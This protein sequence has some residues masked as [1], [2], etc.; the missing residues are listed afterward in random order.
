M[1]DALLS[2][3]REVRAS[4]SNGQ[5]LD[6]RI[7]LPGIAHHFGAAITHPFRAVGGQRTHSL[8]AASS[9]PGGWATACEA[10]KR[11][12]HDAASDSRRAP[13]L[14]EHWVFA[15]DSPKHI[16]THYARRMGLSPSLAGLCA[17]ASPQRRP[18]RWP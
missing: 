4:A 10:A 1:C 8:Q 7:Y 9:A 6:A 2:P 16:I 18:G 12:T 14:S 15:L 11:E 17:V 5:R 3:K 13:G